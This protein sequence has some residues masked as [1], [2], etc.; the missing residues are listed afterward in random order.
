MEVLCTF[1]STLSK[2]K[3]SPF[4]RI[5]LKPAEIYTCQIENQV[6]LED[7]ELQF[8]GQHL[9]ERF[10]NNVNSVSF[11][12]CFITK[13]PRNLLNHFP[14]LHS[15][16]ICGS[17]LKVLNKDDL[18][19]YRHFKSL[20]F[21]SNQIEFLPGDLFEGFENLEKVSFNNN[22]LRVVEPTIF[23]GLKKLH[24]VDLN[25]NPCLNISCKG[26]FVYNGNFVVDL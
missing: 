11:N 6:I 5:R 21:D 25:S 26:D 23:D 19:K 4:D 16:T 3:N 15:L 8:V 2:P 17:N 14:N 22:N 12:L 1:I 18:I 9:N 24:N 13:V 10:N 20:N 7:D